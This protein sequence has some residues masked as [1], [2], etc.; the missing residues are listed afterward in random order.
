MT[1]SVS[2][3]LL[4]ERIDG[5]TVAAFA[6]P[7]LLSDDVIGDVDQQLDLLLQG[8][9]A[10]KVLL[11]FREVR[12]MSS[13]MLA[14]LVKFARRVARAQGKLKLCC[15][16]PHLMEVFRAGRFDRLFEIHDKEAAALD[17]F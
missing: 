4:V 11:S 9:G 15:V 7:A 16:A 13:T 8:L 1:E 2:H 6:D 3:R 17:S 5:V 14:V 10:D 12:F